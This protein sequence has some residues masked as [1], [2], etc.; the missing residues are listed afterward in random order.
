MWDKGIANTLIMQQEE[1]ELSVI[2]DFMDWLPDPDFEHRFYGRLRNVR[3]TV[4]TSNRFHRNRKISEELKEKAVRDDPIDRSVNVDDTF[5]ERVDQVSAV[6]ARRR[7]CLSVLPSFSFT[8][9]GICR[10][11]PG[12]IAVG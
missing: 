5:G 7:L 3:S 8:V 9:T 10:I 11:I 4:C 12:I 6:E 1:H 2:D